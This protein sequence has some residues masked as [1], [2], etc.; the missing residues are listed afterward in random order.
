MTNSLQGIDRTNKKIILHI[1]SAYGFGLVKGSIVVHATLMNI[2]QETPIIPVNNNELKIYNEIIWYLD[3]LT[4]KKLKMSNTSVKIECIHIPANKS[5]SNEKLGYLLF[6]LKDAQTINSISND[7]IENK[8]YKL[9]G[10]KNCSYTLTISL[11]I[12]DFIVKTIK[13][14]PKQIKHLQLINNKNIKDKTNYLQKVNKSVEENTNLKENIEIDLPKSDV[15][16]LEQTEYLPTKEESINVFTSDVQQKIIEELEVW[17]DKQ[18]TLFKEKIKIKEEQLLKE[19]NKKWLDDRK[20]IEE[21]LT[22][23]I[24]KC[25]ALAENVDKMADMLK[26][27]ET[28]VTAKELELACKKD[29]IDNKYISLVQNVQ[30]SN[31]QTFNELNNKIFELTTKLQDS[32]K[33]NILLKKEN[34]QLKNDFNTNYGIQIQHLEN[35]IS[36]LESKYAEANQSCM[37]FKERW[38]TSVRKINQILSSKLYESKTNEHLLN[39]RQNVQNILTNQLVERQQDEDKIK[40]LLNKLSQDMTNINYLSP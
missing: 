27:R 11:R 37:F 23:E 6:N 20:R 10:S 16:I 9:I 31:G 40:Q 2:Q 33:M 21:D 4:L 35:K 3:T 13:T 30:S 17:K 12:E 28:I 29:C 19:F 15:N 1:I 24:S 7:R 26:E 38:I 5:S 36:N 8:S 18:M 14:P 39:K 22:N 34:K 25:K 32:E